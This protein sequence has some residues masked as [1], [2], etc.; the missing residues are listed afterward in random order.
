M[1]LS[2]ERPESLEQLPVRVRHGI[3]LKHCSIRTDQAYV[4]RSARSARV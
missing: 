3:G 4:D 1:E 2:S